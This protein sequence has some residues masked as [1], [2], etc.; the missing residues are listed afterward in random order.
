MCFVKNIIEIVAVCSD[1][2]SGGPYIQHCVLTFR[3]KSRLKVTDKFV[4]TDVKITGSLK[5]SNFRVV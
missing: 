5:P 4:V 2:E 3:H 1:V